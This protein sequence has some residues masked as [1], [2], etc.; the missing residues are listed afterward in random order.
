[1]L[2]I[3]LIPAFCFF[4]G[5][6]NAQQLAVSQFNAGSHQTAQATYIIGEAFN[7][8]YQF[9]GG[10]FT[11]SILGGAAASVLAVSSNAKQN[12]KIYP[13]P[14]TQQ[15]FFV[16]T[17]RATKGYLYSVSG[18]LLRTVDFKSGKNTVE[19]A[20]LIS[21]IYLLKTESGFTAKIIIP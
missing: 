15:K 17:D 16:E 21:G 13:N 12:I 1:M 8:A 3:I 9:T 14:V 4:V 11:E 19:V 18:K 5:S 6:I 20:S 2:K 10:S 7:N